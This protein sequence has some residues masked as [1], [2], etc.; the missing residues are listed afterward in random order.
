MNPI[1]M[2][3]AL[4][5]E[6]GIRNVHSNALGDGQ[7]Y[8]AIVVFYG[9]RNS[10]NGDLGAHYFTAVNNGDNMYIS[11][12]DSFKE[13]GNDALYMAVDKS[14]WLFIYSWGIDF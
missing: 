4:R 8:D 5:N 10:E 6:F 2:G 12:N 3:A 7:E 14:K 1:S 13:K 9:W 11:H